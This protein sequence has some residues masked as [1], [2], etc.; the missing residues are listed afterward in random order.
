MWGFLLVSHLIQMLPSTCNKD[1]LRR[2]SAFL[3]FQI[4][5]HLSNTHRLFPCGSA[6][7]VSALTY[8]ASWDSTGTSTFTLSVTG[9]HL[10]QHQLSHLVSTRCYWTTDV[11]V[12]HGLP[13]TISSTIPVGRYWT[14]GLIDK[15]LQQTD[16]RGGNIGWK[17][18]GSYCVRFGFSSQ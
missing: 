2:A 6:G 17:W 4:K 3:N 16:R 15:H 18:I 1:Q 8:Y 10:Q 9:C 13:S 5:K 11:A 7:G 14:S 12:H